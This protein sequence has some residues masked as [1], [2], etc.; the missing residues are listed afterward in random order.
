MR[1]TAAPVLLLLGG[2]L[3]SVNAMAAPVTYKLD[4]GKSK[5][6]VLVKY[7]RGAT[8]AGHDHIVTPN[9]FAGTVTWDTEDIGACKVHIDF[10]VS[11]LQVDPG[12]SRNFE[13]L[14]GET[15]DGDKKKIR[16][17]LM[18]RHQ[19]EADSHPKIAFDSTSCKGSGSDVT[20]TGTLSMHGVGKTVTTQMNVVAAPDA[21]KARGSFT[22]SHGDWGMEPFS[23][24][25]GALR[26]DD[27]LKFVVDVTGTP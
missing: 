12:S 17:N 22:G 7:D 25:L 20:V 9:T 10:P 27:G 1:T 21:F 3:G 18:G 26:N 16:D 23:A 19:L 13:N 24:L 2:L 11:A 8:I 6:Y 15:S 4:P 5:L 14:E